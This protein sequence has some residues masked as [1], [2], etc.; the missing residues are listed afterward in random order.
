MIENYS[1]TI[2][3][4]DGKLHP[5]DE[6]KPNRFGLFGLHGNAQEW[7]HDSAI[8]YESHI[9]KWVDGELVSGDDSIREVREIRDHSIGSDPTEIG[10]YDREAVAEQ[11]AFTF[12]G[13][14]IART[15]SK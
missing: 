13:F 5:V 8:A 12:V 4:S 3:N 2:E 10:V 15:Y 11:L 1:R 6:L 14:R 7:C 9:R